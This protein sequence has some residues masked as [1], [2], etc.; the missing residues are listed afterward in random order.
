MSGVAASPAGASAAP[1]APEDIVVF[2]G[3]TL[4]REAAEKL[5][6]ACYLPPVSCGDVLRALRSRPK[7]IAIVD[8]L[9][10]HTAAVWHKEILFAI[11]NGVA[12]FGASSMGALRA[13][14]LAAFG[15][16]GIGRIFESYRDG[17]L[18]DDDEVAVLHSSAT[19]DHRV[20]SDPMVNIRATIAAAVDTGVIGAQLGARV[21]AR[22][23]EA[24]YQERSLKSAMEIERAAADPEELDRL[25]RFVDDGGYVDQ[26]KLDALELIGTLTDLRLA[27]APVPPTGRGPSLSRSSHLRTLLADVLCQPVDRPAWWPAEETGAPRRGRPANATRDL[28][29]ILARLLSLGDAIARTRGITPTP[30]AIDRVFERDGLG[31]APEAKDRAYRLARI[32]ALLDRESKERGSR[33][34]WQKYLL[35]LLRAHGEYERLRPGRR[36]R[37]VGRHVSARCNPLFVRMAK[38]WQAVDRAAR[39]RGIGPEGLPDELQ[40]FADDFREARGLES[41]AVTRA[42]LRRNDLDAAGFHELVTALARLSILSDHAQTDTLGAVDIAEDVCWFDDALTLSG[43]RPAESCPKTRPGGEH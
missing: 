22:A 38:L 9:F 7:V 16:V 40:D 4:A 28:L 1:V 5:L 32:Q 41:K 39:A 10:E 8:G 31:L 17:V 24:F 6:P 21:V 42:W 13:A 30:E 37:N 18:T 12:V 25:A 34:G 33:R 3:P 36:A 19:G 2:L 27:G 29:A 15:M 43:R 26:K 20:L 11:E 35:M 14:E 23:K